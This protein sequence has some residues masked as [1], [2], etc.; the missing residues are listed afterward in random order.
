[1]RKDEVFGAISIGDPKGTTAVGTAPPNPDSV[2]VQ[3]GEDS[4]QLN[5]DVDLLGIGNL[6][7]PSDITLGSCGPV[8]QDH[9]HLL[10]ETELHGC[11]STLMMTE[12][13]LVYTFAL[14]YQP[15]ALGATPIIR[16]NGAVV[17]VQCHYMRLHNVSSNAL[18][19]TWIPYHSTLSAEDLIM[20]SLRLMAE[21]VAQKNI[22]S[23]CLMDSKLT[24]SRSEFL[25]RIAD[26]KLQV[27]LDAFRFAQE[28]RSQVLINFFS[29]VKAVD[30]YFCSPGVSSEAVVIAGVVAAVGL[31]CVIV[32]APLTPH[33]TIGEPK[34]T[35]VVGTTRP[36][37]DSV[38]VQCG[39][40]SIQLNVDVDLLGI[41][42]LIQPSDITL[43]SCGPVGQDHS[44]LL[45]ETEL[46]GCDSTLMMTEDTLVYTFALLYQPKALEATPIIRT[47]AAVVG[48]Q[49]HY[50][51]LHNVSSNALKP[52]WI[53]YHSTLSAEDLIMFSLRLM[54]DDWQLERTSNVFFL[55][56]IINIEASVIQANHVSLRV[57]MD[58]CVAT[59]EPN[60]DSMPSY[61]FIYDQGWVSA[62]GNDQ[63]CSCC[64]TG[65]TVRKG[66]SLGPAA[67]QYRGTAFLGPIVVQQPATDIMPESANTPL[68]AEDNR[69]AGVSSEALFIAGV[70]VAVG[71][72]CMIVLVT[73]LWRGF[74]PTVL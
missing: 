61:D 42:N 5:V 11:D 40:D 22:P 74:K 55:G 20:F 36:N 46:H 29:F 25:S 30:L 73:L 6:I 64:D 58:T 57:F 50:M 26:D 44:H 34:G 4:I 62:S 63:V 24:S 35:S 43:G 68:K 2:T 13:T 14:L 39:E 48:V 65:C 19:P 18:K 59:L 23:R 41:G 53:P 28:T 15:K 12:D 27:K 72:V 45:F 56:D 33:P 17:G 31:V 60:M 10:F 67:P 37:P 38:T 54:A 21:V 32:L 3:C 70:V 47:N 51:R 16:T 8:G 7:Q 1:M 52:T 71:L 66:R 49:C 69:A 9:S